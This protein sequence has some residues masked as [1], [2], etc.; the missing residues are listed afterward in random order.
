MAHFAKI[1]NSKVV[2]VIVVKNENAATEEAGKAFIA[3]LD[4]DGD[5]VQT[6]YNKNFR[7]QYAGIGMT[8]NESVFHGPSPYP[9]WILQDD[10]KWSS[11]S[12]RPD[13]DHSW[14]EESVS[15][16]AVVE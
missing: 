9:S 3:S 13:G 15:W 16:V 12:A 1:E 6:S 5:W 4:I 2:N 7:G 8:W 11:P 10:G 14:N